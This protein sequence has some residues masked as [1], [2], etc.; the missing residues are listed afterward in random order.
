MRE[1]SVPVPSADVATLQAYLAWADASILQ[2]VET[3]ALLDRSVHPEPPGG[4]T[5]GTGVSRA[6]RLSRSSR[7]SH[8]VAAPVVGHADPLSIEPDDCV[9]LRTS[10]VLSSRKLELPCSAQSTMEGA[11]AHGSTLPSISL[12]NGDP[13][14]HLRRCVHGVVPLA[15]IRRPS[16]GDGVNAPA[17]A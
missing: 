14:R 10:P 16:H 7:A 15:S 6:V 5:T 4:A 17:D 8:G 1:L 12:P 3:V 13:L 9:A 2:L 11:P